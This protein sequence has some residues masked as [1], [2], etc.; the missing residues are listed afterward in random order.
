MFRP[1]IKVFVSPLLDWPIESGPH[2]FFLWL[3][4][5]FFYQNLS[6]CILHLVQVFCSVYHFE[7]FY[8]KITEIR[9]VLIHISLSYFGTH[10][11]SFGNRKMFHQP[12]DP[13]LL[14]TVV[15]GLVKG[16]KYNFNVGLIIW[17]SY[18]LLHDKNN[19]MTCAPSEDC[20]QWVAKSTWFFMRTATTD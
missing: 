2:I 12:S 19:K 1:K 5:F 8:S 15:Y 11:P 10:F 17:Q 4:L 7:V 14:D 3:K 16:N 6:I 18:E 20:T 13:S 9:L